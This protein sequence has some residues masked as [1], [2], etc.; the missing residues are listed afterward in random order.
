MKFEVQ[1]LVG[2]LPVRL[3]MLR[4]EVRKAMTVPPEE[5][6]KAA[7]GRYTADAF[8]G[9]F[10]VFYEGDEP[11]VEYIELSRD[12]G[13]EAILDGANVFAVPA[14]DLVSQL[15]RHSPFDPNDPE[16]GYSF[17]FPQ[18]ELALWRPVPFAPE[19]RFFSTVGIGV[20]GYFSGGAG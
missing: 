3:G 7:D 14:D 1:P 2:V 13:L 20:R 17:V 12:S 4:A 10:H 15:T 8:H 11:A 18:L 19:G 5:Y 9:G 6:R 16:L